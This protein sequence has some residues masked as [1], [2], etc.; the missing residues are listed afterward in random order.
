MKFE[1]YVVLLLSY[2]IVVWWFEPVMHHGLAEV[3]AS[4]NYHHLMRFFYAHFV[5]LGRWGAEAGRVFPWMC[6]YILSWAFFSRNVLLNSASCAWV[7]PKR[8]ATRSRVSVLLSTFLWRDRSA[9]ISTD[10]RIGSE[11]WSLVQIA[12]FYGNSSIRFFPETAK[13]MCLLFTRRC[14][15]VSK[16]YVCRRNCI[17]FRKCSR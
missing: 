16:H 8:I 13:N 10:R 9:P 3:D 14:L 17:V 11:L 7:L 4:C 6:L 1:P 5:L 12:C 2:V 15:L